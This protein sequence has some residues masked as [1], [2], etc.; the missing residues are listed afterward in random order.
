M[1]SV[2]KNLT[3]SAVSS[4]L[5]VPSYKCIVFEDVLKGIVSAKQAGMTVIGVYDFYSRHETD[6]I[7]AAADK[8]IQNFNELL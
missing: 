1:A 3:W 7:T 5:S 2:T 4:K 6:L 8:Y